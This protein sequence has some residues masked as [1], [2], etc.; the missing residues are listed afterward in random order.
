MKKQNILILC[1]LAFVAMFIM[2]CKKS[3]QLGNYIGTFSGTYN[4][5]NTKAEI[6]TTYKFKITQNTKNKI[7]IQ[8]MNNNTSSTLQKID[9]DSIVGAI[10]FSNVYDPNNSKGQTL[11]IIKIRG[12]YQE[13]DEKTIIRG[14]FTGD[15]FIDEKKI[16]ASGEFVLNQ[17]N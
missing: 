1:I 9:N 12:Q 3:P 15:V 6:S 5:N 16:P 10:G 13:I 8:E 17:A 2:S 11:N 4:Y 14:I 7:V